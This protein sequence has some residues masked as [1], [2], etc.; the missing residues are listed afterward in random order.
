METGLKQ[1]YG[2]F[3]FKFTSTETGFKITQLP[4]S[5]L[6]LGDLL[7]LIV[8]ENQNFKFRSSWMRL[9]GG[10]ICLTLEDGVSTFFHIL[11]TSL[12]SNTL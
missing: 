10:T 5:F 7:Q 11:V 2:N 6:H 4:V 3:L 12:P 9:L 1:V 8:T